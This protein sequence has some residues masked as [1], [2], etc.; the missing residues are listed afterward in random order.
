MNHPLCVTGTDA[1]V[2]IL[3]ST[4]KSPTRSCVFEKDKLLVIRLYK[5]FFRNVPESQLQVDYERDATDAPAVKPADID[6][7]MTALTR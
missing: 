1:L 2:T 4:I 7:V 3:P 6:D 5:P